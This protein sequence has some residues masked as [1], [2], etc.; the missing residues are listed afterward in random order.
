MTPKSQHQSFLDNAFPTRKRKPPAGVSRRDTAENK[1]ELNMS[2]RFMHLRLAAAVAAF[3][4][5]TAAGCAPRHQDAGEALRL[6]HAGLTVLVD[7][8]VA[9]EVSSGRNA[10]SV[11]ENASLAVEAA[12]AAQQT[13][14]GKGYRVDGP[15][16]ISVGAQYE[17]D[18]KLSV[19]T[20]QG[21]VNSPEVRPKPFVVYPENFGPDARRK[22]NDLFA[23]A[24]RGT[25]SPG[26]PLD[27]T[28]TAGIL[29][30]ACTGSSR[31]TAG[32]DASLSIAKLRP[33]LPLLSNARGGVGFQLLD[34]ASGK[35]VWKSEGRVSAFTP[36]AVAR[37]VRDLL[38]ALPTGSK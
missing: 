22:I 13:L 9:M 31:S 15:V 21:P 18:E 25:G 29:L 30:V 5:V 12:K 27:L 1:E 20:V 17:P 32:P 4:A 23:W 2:D 38:A 28:E 37:K 36:D 14:A 34:R 33:G 35:V 16:I 26:G 6:S 11:P 10:V 24:R 3:I 8:S 19:L 7:S